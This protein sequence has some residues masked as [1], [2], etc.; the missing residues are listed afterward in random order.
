MPGF[1][2]AL[3]WHCHMRGFQSGIT[4][5]APRLAGGRTPRLTAAARQQAGRLLAVA[6]F[7]SGLARV[8]GHR[9]CLTPYRG[10]FLANMV[11]DFPR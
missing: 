1:G 2:R 8:P 4:E 6:G 9:K 5:A 3:K 11:E 10:G 7:R